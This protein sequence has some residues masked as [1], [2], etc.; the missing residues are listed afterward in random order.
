M[1][2][3]LRPLRAEKAFWQRIDGE[4]TPDAITSEILAYSVYKTLI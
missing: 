1:K 3:P 4:M 2:K